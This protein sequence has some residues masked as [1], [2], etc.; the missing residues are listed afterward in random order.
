MEEYEALELYGETESRIGK[1]KDNVSRKI[2]LTENDLISEYNYNT[3][4]ISRLAEPEEFGFTE[5]YFGGNVAKVAVL[6]DS[7]YVLLVSRNFK[8]L[9]IHI[10]N[11]NLDKLPVEQL[12][13]LCYKFSVPYG[14][15]DSKKILVDKLTGM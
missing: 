10:P 9:G 11:N 4:K 12:K 8:T 15:K 13:E 1:F 2:I 6:K 7:P 5:R 3:A 14:N